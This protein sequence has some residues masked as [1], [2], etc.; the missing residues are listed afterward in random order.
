[1]ANVKETRPKTVERNLN[2]WTEDDKDF[3][4]HVMNIKAPKVI[5]PKNQ[6]SYN[7]PKEYL[8]TSEELEKKAKHEA[9]EDIIPTFTPA[10]YTHLRKV[11]YYQQLINEKF[12]S[13]SS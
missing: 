1:M 2:I 9:Y 12:T 3:K 10:A 4:D 11:P 13:G 8:L 7:P 5:P 6:E